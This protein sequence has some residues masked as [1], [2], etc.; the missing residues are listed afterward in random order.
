MCVCMYVCMYMYI[1]IYICIYVCMYV[2]MYVIYIYI[3]IA[4][5]YIYNYSGF[6]FGVLSLQSEPERLHLRPYHPMHAFD[7]ATHCNILL[8]SLEDRNTYP[9]EP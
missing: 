4:H 3:H 9:I 5:V 7:F 2:C 6:S 8:S 1:Y